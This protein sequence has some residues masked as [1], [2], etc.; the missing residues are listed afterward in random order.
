MK[1]KDSPPSFILTRNSN[2][3]SKFYVND[4]YAKRKIYITLKYLA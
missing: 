1:N 2:W 4:D 3:S